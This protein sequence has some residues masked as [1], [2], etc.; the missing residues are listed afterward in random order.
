MLHDTTLIT[1]MADDSSLPSHCTHKRA[2]RKL[3]P[4]DQKL[5][6]RAKLGGADAPEPPV[7]HSAPLACRSRAR[8]VED[9]SSCIDGRDDC[10]SHFCT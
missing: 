1:I 6:S 9:V 8:R 10:P 4:T 7:D 2:V 3:A 5:S